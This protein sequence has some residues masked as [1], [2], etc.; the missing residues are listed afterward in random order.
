MRRWQRQLVSTPQPSD[1]SRNLF[2]NT[3]PRASAAH[4]LPKLELTTLGLGTP[5]ATPGIAIEYVVFPIG[6]VISTV[7]RMHDGASI[8]VMLIGREGFF[9]LPVVFGDD[10]S[11]NEAMIQIAGTV[12]RIRSSDFLASANAD[13]ALN[14]RL[15]KYA[16]TAFTTIL[17]F[18]G[19]NRLHSVNE[20]FARWLLMAHD[21]VAGDE[22]LLTHEYLATMLGVRRPAISQA[23]AALEQGGV[24]EYHR[25]RI[26]VRDRSALEAAA[27]ECYAVVNNESDRLLGYDPRKVAHD[28]EDDVG[29]SARL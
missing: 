5:V 23:A 16:Q 13:R 2:L 4:L 15:L 19:C 7:T 21:R 1:L 12:L 9:G 26:V 8:E 20:R 17:Q 14:T 27:C 28:A 11:A 29:I 3:L 6:G 22:L 10:T 25:G 18:A 24:I